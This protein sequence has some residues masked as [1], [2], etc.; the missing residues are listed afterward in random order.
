MNENQ[1]VKPLLS[2][3]LITYNH[4]KYIREAIDSILMQ[5]V[6]FSLQLII[7]DD[8]S[9]DG[10]RDILLEYKAK[11]PDFIKLILQSENVGARKNWTELMTSPDSK[12]ISYFEGDDYWTDPNKLQ[13][14]VDFL[15]VN[16]DYSICTH[17][18]S[19]MF[20]DSN[21]KLIRK[22]EWLGQEHR[23]T[24]T[25]NDLLMY[26]SGGATCSLLFRRSAIDPFPEGFKI[27]GG[28]DWA[29]QIFCAEKG[30]MKYFKEIMGVY[31]KHSLGLVS[32]TKSTI[33]YKEFGT[34]VCGYF[35]K[36]FNYKYNK[37]IS[38]QMYHY[39]YPNLAD[40]YFEN[41][42]FTLYLIT[43]L[44]R[45]FVKIKYMF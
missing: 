13:K 28:G 32:T 7:A 30:K 22:V 34:D 9:T 2:V 40:A 43:C 27:L 21:D 15:E 38:Y 4:V 39:F 11:Y 14:Q 23:E 29:L 36:Y 19:V 25:V 37:E 18:V 16:T 35:D 5:K 41:K 24:Y 3:C 12:Y 44:K 10:T 33:I 8:F 1:V 26:G 42:N 17:N 31:R 45:F 20:Y 6:N